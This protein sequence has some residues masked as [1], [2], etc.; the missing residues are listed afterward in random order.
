LRDL[1]RH[2]ATI[3]AIV[4]LLA[5]TAFAAAR[6]DLIGTLALG[7]LRYAPTV[8]AV[9]A[10]LAAARSFSAAERNFVRALAVLR[11]SDLLCHAAP[12]FALIPLLTSAGA[13][14]A[15]ERNLVLPLARR[16]SDLR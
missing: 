16:L 9:I 2:A 12:V 5:S 14:A 13:L 4:P 6:L 1:A 10:L 8:L 3:P 7:D 15:A 11:L